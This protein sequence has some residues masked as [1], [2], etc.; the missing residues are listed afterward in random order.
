MTCVT[1]LSA[2]LP[3]PLPA[4]AP[5]FVASL[6]KRAVNAP[7]ID[8]IRPIHKVLT[9]IGPS[10]LDAVH[11]TIITDLQDEL[12]SIV[13]REVQDPSLS[14]TSLAI[15]ALLTPR[16]HLT[17][18]RV[19]AFQS[20][21]SQIDSVDKLSSNNERHSAQRYFSTLK[22]AAKTMDLVVI[23]AI[24]AC[25][26]NYDLCDLEIMDNMRLSN[27]II[28]AIDHDLR[29]GWVEKNLVKCKKLRER[30]ASQ[31]INVDIR[32]AV[33][34]LSCDPKIFVHW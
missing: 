1:F 26:R 29:K 32:V 10:L 25:S 5:A 13:H 28:L 34:C 19:K 15:L 3:V 4:S 14:L 8:N 27:E 17:N 30:L 33:C 22:W 11:T 12:K 24:R 23:T 21:T 20:H 9:G 6:F 2:P 18:S 31:D 16:D 7:S